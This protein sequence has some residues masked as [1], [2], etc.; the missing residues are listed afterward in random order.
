MTRSPC[1]SSPH[2]LIAPSG[3]SARRSAYRLPRSGWPCWYGVATSVM[4]LTRRSHRRQ[5][6]RRADGRGPLMARRVSETGPHQSPLEDGIRHFD[7]RYH[8]I[9][10]ALPIAD[11][12]PL[13]RIKPRPRRRAIQSGASRTDYPCLAASFSPRLN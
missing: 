13:R 9:M 12:Q 6:D 4:M 7:A 10:S 11:S 5:R 2:R 8:R 1:A 3:W